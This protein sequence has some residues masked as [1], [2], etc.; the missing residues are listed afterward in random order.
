MYKFSIRCQ[1]FDNKESAR[2]TMK[3]LTEETEVQ[4][5]IIVKWAKGFSKRER[6]L[7]TERTNL[8]IKKFTH[9]VATV[10]P[11]AGETIWDFSD[12]VE[13]C[14]S[15]GSNFESM[16]REAYNCP[17]AKLE[18]IET[19]FNDKHVRVTKE[20]AIQSKIWEKL[21]GGYNLI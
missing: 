1:E 8:W 15:D 14:F 7:S 4:N 9:G 20:D 12:L 17:N 13:G 5:T 10:E 2:L 18:A 11:A 6:V 21:S 19:I 3:S 16:L